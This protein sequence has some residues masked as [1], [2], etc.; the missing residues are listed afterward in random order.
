MAEVTAAE[1]TAAAKVAAMAVAMAKETLSAPEVV[2]RV[3]E[4]GEKGKRTVSSSAM[5][6]SSSY[7]FGPPCS[8]RKWA[9][10]WHWFLFL[11]SSPLTLCVAEWRLC[12]CM[13]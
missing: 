7:D 6:N 9:L 10:N 2:A 8:L 11:F 5:T 4:A 13:R 3:K 1:A 12:T